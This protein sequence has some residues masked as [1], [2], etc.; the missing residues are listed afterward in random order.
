MNTALALPRQPQAAAAASAFSLSPA[1]RA[2]IGF[3]A[4]AMSLACLYALARLAAGVAPDHPNLRDAAIM[5]H[6]ATVLP[7]IPLGGYLLLARKGTQSHKQLGKLWVILMVATAISAI[8]IGGLDYFSWI[9]I[10]VPIT[11][12]GAWKTIATARAGNI[13]AHKSHLVGMYLGA[14]MIPGIAAFAMPGRLVN[15]LVFGG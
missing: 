12:H 14:L 11:L 2:I 7:A 4:T 5:L 13:A 10:F 8:F 9:H 1:T 6:V 15:T 3:A